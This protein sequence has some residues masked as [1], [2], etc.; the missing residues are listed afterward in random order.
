MEHMNLRVLLGQFIR[1]LARAIR[2][3]I[4]DDQHVDP[5]GQG[6]NAPGE[7]NNVVPLV[8]GGHNDQAIHE[9]RVRIGGVK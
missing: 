9:H 7:R 6:Q 3:V 8:V 5:R 1:E 2:R 4:V